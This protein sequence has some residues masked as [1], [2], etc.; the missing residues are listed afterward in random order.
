M[1]QGYLLG[2]WAT[3]DL[4]AL[5]RVEG[6]ARKRNFLTGLPGDDLASNL[7]RPAEVGLLYRTLSALGDDVAPGGEEEVG[8]GTC[9]PVF[10]DYELHVQTLDHS[11]GR[12]SLGRRFKSL[13]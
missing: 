7:W 12:R 2:I 1:R 8:L 10:K 3:K 4:Q 13:P 6:Y 11:L 5:E 9:L